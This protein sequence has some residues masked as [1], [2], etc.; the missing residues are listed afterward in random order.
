[1]LA[2]RTILL[3][4]AVAG[5]Q[6]LFV[7]AAFPHVR[8]A[9]AGVACNACNADESIGA[10]NPQ[11]DPK[12]NRCVF[13]DCQKDYVMVDGYGV[14]FEDDKRAKITSDKVTKELIR[15]TKATKEDCGYSHYKCTDPDPSHLSYCARE[16]KL[17]A[18]PSMV[19]CTA[20]E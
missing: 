12:L 17:S 4:G 11:W 15:C 20:K 8:R 19:G 7:S 6:A 18:R 10:V 1:M 3:V 2:S 14:P 16:S 5:L 9:D 13:F